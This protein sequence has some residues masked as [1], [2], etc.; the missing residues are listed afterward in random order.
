M[1][2]SD[3]GCGISNDSVRIHVFK[4]VII[5]NAFSP[6]GDG[7]NDTWNIKALNSYNDYELSVF[8]R[9]GRI[10]FTTKNYSKPWDGSFNGRALPV[11]TYYYLIDLKQGLPKLKGFVVILR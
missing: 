5:P 6:N 3:N 2:S 11:G 10:V 4:T 8:N 1:V 9:Y 7:I